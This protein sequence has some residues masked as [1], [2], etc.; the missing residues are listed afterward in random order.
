LSPLRCEIHLN[1]FSIIPCNNG[2]IALNKEYTLFE[3]LGLGFV[4]GLRA[5]D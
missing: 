3:S 1:V 4:Q 2:L 5:L